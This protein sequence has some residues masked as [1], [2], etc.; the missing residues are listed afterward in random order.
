[1]R[2]APL[3]EASWMTRS[4]SPQSMPRSRVEVQTTARSSPRAMAASTLRRCSAASEPW[5]RAIGRL[6]SFSRHSSWKAN[7]AW[8]RV[9]TK[10]SAVRAP[11]DDVIDLRHG[12]LGGVAG[13]GHLALATAA[14]RRSAAR[15]AAPR[16]RS[17][18]APRRRRHPAPDHLR[19]V[20]RGREADAAQA[21][22]RTAAAAPGRAPAGR[23]AWRA[24][25]RGSRRGSRTR[26]SSK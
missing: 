4:T 12:V 25:W 13:P 3:G 7:S 11:R 9:L 19:I 15:P 26:R 14:R 22:A 6:S 18:S 8:K 10:T 16:T 5:C 23:R 17:T 24:R 2:E 1:M 20:D 21:R